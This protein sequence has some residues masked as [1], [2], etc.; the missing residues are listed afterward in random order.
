M[1]FQS[2]AHPR[3][4]RPHLSAQVPGV[5]QSHGAIPHC[6]GSAG[7]LLLPLETWSPWGWWGWEQR[8]QG[9][10]ARCNSGRREHESNS[11]SCR[12]LLLHWHKAAPAHFQ[13][14]RQFQAVLRVSLPGKLVF[15]QWWYRMDCRVLALLLAAEGGIRSAGQW[16][17]LF[18]PPLG[19]YLWFVHAEPAVLVFKI[20]LGWKYTF[21]PLSIS[22]GKRKRTELWRKRDIGRN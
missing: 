9:P 2:P 8:K 19:Y 5:P 16:R 1:L 7:A 17:G 11:L 12:P 6:G 15:D 21:F 10:T 4:A 13:A 3:K 20:I 22:M 18:L 14:G